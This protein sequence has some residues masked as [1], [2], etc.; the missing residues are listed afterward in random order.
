MTG[1]LP[2]VNQPQRWLWSRWCRLFR[3]WRRASHGQIAAHHGPKR[4]PAR[5]DDKVGSLDLERH[6]HSANLAG[7]D[8]GDGRSARSADIGVDVAQVIW[9]VGKLQSDDRI[10]TGSD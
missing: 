9:T 4:N 10:V 7:G 2:Q 1:C 5:S 3:V 6:L 8:I